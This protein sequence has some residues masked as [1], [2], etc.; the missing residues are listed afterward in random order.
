MTTKQLSVMNNTTLNGLKE[1]NERLKVKLAEAQSNGFHETATLLKEM[2]E[3][4]IESIAKLQ[5]LEDRKKK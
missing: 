5:E 2:I 4:N 3:G 1:H